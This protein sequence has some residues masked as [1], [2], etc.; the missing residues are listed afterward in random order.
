[1][2][3][4]KGLEL[5]RSTGGG[6]PATEAP[7]SRPGPPRR[8]LLCSTPSLEPGNASTLASAFVYGLLKEVKRSLLLKIN[9]LHP[10]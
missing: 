2:A 10:D 6:L 1:M 8:T 4:G 3:K 5:G 7:F 9:L